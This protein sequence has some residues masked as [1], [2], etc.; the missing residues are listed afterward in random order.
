MQSTGRFFHPK[1]HM[2]SSA[3]QT[4]TVRDADDQLPGDA[5]AR[6]KARGN[7]VDNYSSRILA[8]AA[9]MVSAVTLLLLNKAL[10][11]TF[12]FTFTVLIIQSLFTIVLNGTIVL[13]LWR[14]YGIKPYIFSWSELFQF[15][16]VVA[17]FLLILFTG[18]EVL[19]FVSVITFVSLRY[20]SCFTSFFGEV[21]LLGKPFQWQLVPSLFV[22]VTGERSYKSESELPLIC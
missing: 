18:F 19:K 1:A 17:F 4:A 8:A 5:D 13:V 7:A 11:I 6:K 10:A 2:S 21:L 14:Y 20:L 15:L 22:I 9:Y 12:P 3:S 16:P